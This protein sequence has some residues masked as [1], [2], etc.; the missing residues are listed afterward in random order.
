M[1]AETELL[2]LEPDD[3][4]TTVVRRLRET[5]APRIVLVA[6][7]RSKATTSAVALR[8]L[9]E[10]AAEEGREIAL[11]ADPAARALAAEAAIPAFASVAEASGNGTSPAVA[12]PAPRRA[13]I[14]VVRGEPE[15]AAPAPLA[16]PTLP[17][18][19]TR[20]I[21]VPVAQPEPRAPRP[22]KR[23]R[24]RP[25]AA[26]RL[27]PAAFGALVAMILL[28][29]ALLA[30]VAPAASV[31]IRPA[32]VDVGP[33]AYDVEV[34]VAGTDS[35]ELQSTQ[36]GT[37][38]GVHQDPSPASGTVVFLNYGYVTVEIPQ[39]TTVSASG[40]V[41]FTTVETVVAPAGELQG[42][43]INPGQASVGVVA[44]EPGPGGNVAAEAI[45]TVEDRQVERYLRG[46]PN[47]TGRR[48]INPEATSGGSLNEQPEITQADVD[49]VKQAITQDLAAQLAERMAQDP[50]R[51]YPPA[52][53]AEPTITVPEGLVGSV[54]QATF[55]LSGSLPYSRP[56]GTRADAEAAARARLLDDPA[57]APA[58]TVILEESIA[59]EIGDAVLAGDRL[60][61][62]TSVRATA[63]TSI[64]PD[65]VRARIAGMT[66]PQA[67]AAL[68]DLGAVQVDLWPD[69]V[70]H[71]PGLT[72]RIDVRIETT[73][74]PSPVPTGSEGG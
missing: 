29:G 74:A 31:V 24:T 1:A 27:P 35:G 2:Y 28:A 40:E 26:R 17:S 43:G 37:A 5:D 16:P 10:L 44:V 34:D 65:A 73:E 7:G 6:P 14:H 36:P 22:L 62:A 50:A 42:F 25:A 30:G 15:G 48:V 69:W 56:Y 70:D 41:L 21:S 55:E 9:A 57:A 3:E 59:V 71:V 64:D 54:G 53:S 38:T 72:W 18:D 52:E 46:F 19:E 61:V 32:T 11:V 13:P 47:Q 58:G 39:G 20:T 60:R 4:I 51:V 23:T 66:V 33:V 12:P 67:Q 63:A 68:A 45:D 49:A 8:L